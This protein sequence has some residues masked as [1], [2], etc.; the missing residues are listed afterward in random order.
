MYLNQI[1]GVIVCG[2][3]YKPAGR[4]ISLAIYTYLFPH[5]SQLYS[6]NAQVILQQLLIFVESTSI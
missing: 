1:A 3:A 6:R 4:D 2:V 5:F